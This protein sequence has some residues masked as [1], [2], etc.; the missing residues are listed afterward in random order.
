MKISCKRVVFQQNSLD[1][2]HPPSQSGQVDT[3]NDSLSS[4]LFEGINKWDNSI[5]W[6][7]SSSSLGKSLLLDTVGSSIDHSLLTIATTRISGPNQFSEIRLWQSKGRQKRSFDEPSTLPTFAVRQLAV[8]QSP[9]TVA[10]FV[11]V[12]LS[13]PFMQI[14][15]VNHL[16]DSSLVR[17]RNSLESDLLANR[18][19]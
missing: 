9:I 5:Y 7:H 12:P 6:Q 2:G 18:F 11:S 17:E 15:F 4:D 16:F 10:T 13:K 1:S 3:S 14:R 8:T 19:N